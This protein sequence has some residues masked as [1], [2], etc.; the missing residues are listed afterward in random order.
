MKRATAGRIIS[1]FFNSAI[2]L[3]CLCLSSAKRPFSSRICSLIFLNEEGSEV[4]PADRAVLCSGGMFLPDPHGQSITSS[5]LLII[6]HSLH[7]GGPQQLAIPQVALLYYLVNCAVCEPTLL[8][9]FTTMWCAESAFVPI[10]AFI[11][12]NPHFLIA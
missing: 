11:G 7:T 4:T 3:S 8:T 5:P 12:F 6:L 2:S 1:P 9:S 10:F